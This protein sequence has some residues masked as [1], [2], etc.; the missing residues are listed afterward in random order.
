[1]ERVT[2]DGYFSMDINLPENDVAVEF[3]GPTHYYTTSDT[4]SSRDA[5]MTRTAKTE[6]RDSL[7]AKECARVVT[8]PWFEFDNCKTPEA[9]RAYVNVVKDKLA[10]EAGVEV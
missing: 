6:L 5:S 4:S 1:V 10:R 9:C 3:D 8:V 2:A 7:L